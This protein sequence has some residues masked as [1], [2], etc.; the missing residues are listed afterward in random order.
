MFNI[1]FI[2]INL[3]VAAPELVV[4]WNTIE[5]DHFEFV[6]DGRDPNVDKCLENGLEAQYRFE[7]KLCLKGDALFAKCSD[8]LI[9][10]RFL[11]QDLITRDYRLVS[12]RHRDGKEP[13]VENFSKLSDAK[14]SLRRI[15]SVGLKVFLNSLSAKPDRDK[16]KL[17]ARLLSKC[18]GE[19]SETWTRLS[20]YLS[21]GLIRIESSD[22]GWQTYNLK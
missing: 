10:T 11:S 17:K 1:A 13:I 4:N 8:E 6:V 21:F 5:S 16:L 3:I 7:A 19:V 20:Y 2:F 15:D 9:E 14:K 22:S 18:Q 12:D